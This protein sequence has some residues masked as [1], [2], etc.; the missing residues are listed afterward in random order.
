MVEM[1]KVAWPTQNELTSNA[2]IYLGALVL[3]GALLAVADVGLAA[4]VRLLTVGG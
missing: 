4:L 1:R 2:T 3:V